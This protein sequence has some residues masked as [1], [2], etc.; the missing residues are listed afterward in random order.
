MIIRVA[1]VNWVHRALLHTQVQQFIRKL[2]VGTGQFASPRRV[3]SEPPLRTRLYAVPCGAVC[4]CFLRA[5]VN[6][7]SCV[8]VGV[9]VRARGAFRH[10]C[11]REVVCPGHRLRRTL[12][13]TSPSRVVPVSVRGRRA[14]VN[15]AV[16]RFVV[17]PTVCRT[18]I[19]THS[20]VQNCEQS[21]S[22]R[23]FWYAVPC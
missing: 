5:V 16:S 17:S 12:T 6:A 8:V 7:S 15:Y 4:V 9:V 22:L 1:V 2:L 21:R 13:H 18:L 23:T 3:H 14:F 10:A 19:D 20:H 11:S